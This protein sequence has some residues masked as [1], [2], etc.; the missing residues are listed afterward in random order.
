M[1]L[2]KEELTGYLNDSLG[3]DCDEIDDAAPLFSSGL[4]DS[5]ALVSLIVFIENK[6]GIKVQP[7]EVNL[8][9]M[10]SVE[11]I[12]RFVEGKVS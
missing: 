12:L 2:T 8:D 5:F 6:C 1:K 4:I 7:M 3:L 11:R 10:D 9:N